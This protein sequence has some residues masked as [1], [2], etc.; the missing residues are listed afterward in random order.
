MG[1]EG[2]SA[3]SG[4]SHSGGGGGGGGMVGVDERLVETLVAYK[5]AVDSRSLLPITFV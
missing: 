1:T 5:D 4:G 3:K 2:A